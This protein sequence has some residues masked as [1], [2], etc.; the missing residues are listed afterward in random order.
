M[1]ILLFSGKSGAFEY[2]TPHDPD[3]EKYYSFLYR[4]HVW[5][6]DKEYIKAFDMVIPSV[7]NGFIY[8]CISSGISGSV[9]P[10]FATVEKG[11]T[12]DNTVLWKAIPFNSFLDRGDNI[13]S[14]TWSVDDVT[15]NITNETLTSGYLTS[16]VL[17]NVDSTLEQVVLTNEVEILRASSI[18]ETF[19]RS[20]LLK[21]LQL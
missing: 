16:C 4:P 5:E 20:I 3:E 10:T 15:A 18:S 9:E 1:S 13:I 14:S 21:I 7:A 11:Q 19:N 6:A 12:T 2:P 17:S 8:T